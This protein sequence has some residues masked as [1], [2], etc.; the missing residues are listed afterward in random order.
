VQFRE[1]RLDNGLEIIAEC[2]PQA[3]SMAMG[4]FVKTGARDESDEIAGVSHFLEHMAFKGTSKRSAADVNRELDEMGSH[5]NAQTGE[6]RTMYYAAVLPEFQDR[7]VELLSD[8]MRPALRENDFE[9]EKQ[10]IIEEILMYEDQPPYGAHEKCMAAHFGTHPLGRSVL[11]TVESVGGMKP[12]QMQAYFQQRYSPRNITLAAAGKVDFDR[13][14]AEADKH[15]GS[16]KPFE[17]PRD[18]PR[19]AP[20]SGFQLFHKEA[21]SQQYSTQI[22]G[23]PS[24]NDE[25]RYAG[26][27]LATVVGDESGSRF[28]WDLIDTG[29]A[30]CAAMGAYEFQGTGILMTFLCC[31]PDQTAEN[32]QRIRDIELELQQHG[33]S[34]T[35]LVQAKSKIC[36]HI[37]LQSERPASRLFATGV[38]WLQR[39]E[40]RTVREIVDSYQAVTRADVAAVLEK[41]PLTVNTTVTIGPLTELSPPD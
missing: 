8:I 9:T 5:S 7:T 37:V 32:L 14:V 17:S 22:S 19:A 23:G 6:E 33:I 18:T 16:W 31:A 29:L 36:S 28:F 4:F 30:E 12:S 3:Y 39:R 1:H 38:N 25:D 13:L 2:N 20:H 10:V 34:D 21:S 26:R 35:E 11:G 41:Y 24:A 40:Y 15:C 27:I